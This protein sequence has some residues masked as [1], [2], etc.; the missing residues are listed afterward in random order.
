MDLNSKELYFSRRPN[1]KLEI[2]SLTKIMTCC[3]SLLL[4][5]RFNINFKTEILVTDEAAG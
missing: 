4:V 2:A 3:I 1:S 5:K